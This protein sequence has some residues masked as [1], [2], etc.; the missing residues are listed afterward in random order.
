MITCKYQDLD[1]AEHDEN[2]IPTLYDRD[3][4]HQVY[5]NKLPLQNNVKAR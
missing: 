5:S 1:V 3:Q 4:R 2:L